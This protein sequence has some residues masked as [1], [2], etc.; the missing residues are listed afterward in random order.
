VGQAV[1]DEALAGFSAAEIR[2]LTELLERVR[3]NLTS[4]TEEKAGR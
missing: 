3:H 4:V 1:A 2:S